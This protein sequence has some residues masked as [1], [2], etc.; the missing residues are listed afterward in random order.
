MNTLRSTVIVVILALFLFLYSDHSFGSEKKNTIDEGR[1]QLISAQYEDNRGIARPVILR[2]DTKTGKTNRLISD[3]V[4][5]GDKKVEVLYYGE[6]YEDFI[7]MLKSIK[8]Y[9]DIMKKEIR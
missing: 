7:E 6:I 1:Y 5:I 4:P 2:I 3:V 9:E 8:S